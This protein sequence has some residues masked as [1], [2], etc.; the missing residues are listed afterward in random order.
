VNL[1]HRL[2]KNSVTEETGYRAYTLY[3]DAAI[4]Q[5]GLGDISQTMTSHSEQYEH[6]GEVDTHV[7]DMHPVWQAKEDETR[8]EIPQGEWLAREELDLP[9]PLHQVWDILTIPEYRALLMESKWQEIQNRQNG[10]LAPGSMYQCFH[11]DGRI[12]TQTILEWQPFER[13]VTEDTTPVPHATCLIELRLTPFETPAVHGTRL[14]LTCGKARGPW[15][16]RTLCNLVGGILV[17]RQFRDGKKA[18]LARLEKEIAKGKHRAPEM[19]AIPVELI[20]AAVTARL[21]R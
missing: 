10:R 3:T 12:T 8:I 6:L 1:I 20:G 18:F 14:I 4:R 5:L 17:K 21:E 11:G 7:Q 13:M 15:L 2:L 16:N 9:I 19:A